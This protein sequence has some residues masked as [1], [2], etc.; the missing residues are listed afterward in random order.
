MH[1]ASQKTTDI[2]MHKNKS[3]KHLKSI[4]HFFSPFK[5]NL[6]SNS[7]FLLE[8]FQFPCPPVGDVFILVQCF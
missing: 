3:F 2:S 6:G 8:A 5:L 1:L 4:I 7:A